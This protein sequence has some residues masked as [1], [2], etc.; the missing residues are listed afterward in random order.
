MGKR[1]FESLSE[2]QSA[3]SKGLY[4]GDEVHHLPEYTYRVCAPVTVEGKTPLA[5]S[6]IFWVKDSETDTSPSLYKAVCFQ[7]TFS[8]NLLLLSESE[9]FG[10]IVYNVSKRCQVFADD[11]PITADDLAATMISAEYGKFKF[12]LSPRLGL[13]CR[14]EQKELTSTQDLCNQ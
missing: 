11:D 13:T 14:L 12:L 6:Y 3:V 8:I 9:Q 5:E 10:G 4:E 7:V 1:V 2:L